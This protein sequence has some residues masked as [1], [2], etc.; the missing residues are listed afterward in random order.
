MKITIL[1]RYGYIMKQNFYY[2]SGISPEITKTSQIGQP[3]ALKSGSPSYPVIWEVVLLTVYQTIVAVQPIQLSPRVS[4]FLSC[5]STARR[6]LIV[7]REGYIPL[8]MWLNTTTHVNNTFYPTA[9]K[10]RTRPTPSNACAH[11]HMCT[12]ITLLSPTPLT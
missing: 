4:L 3:E 5:N 1:Q 8:N 2:L 9:S 6:D 10:N 11:T 7:T 12:A